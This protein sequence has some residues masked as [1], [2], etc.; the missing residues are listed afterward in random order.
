[1]W[2][3]QPPMGW[4]HMGMAHG[5]YPQMQ[6][7]QQQQ[8][9]APPAQ[10]P[11]DGVLRQRI[12]TVARFC[13]QNG[14]MFESST[15]SKEAHNPLF[16]FMFGGEGAEYFL[17]CRYCLSVGEQDPGACAERFL[18]PVGA[19]N[20]QQQQQQQ[21]VPPGFAPPPPPGMP[22]R[23]DGASLVPH[24]EGGQGSVGVQGGASSSFQGDPSSSSSSVPGAQSHFAQP[25]SSPEGGGEMD[26][27]IEYDL[28]A[29]LVSYQ[30][31]PVQEISPEVQKELS[32]VLD[33]LQP[34]MGGGGLS[35]ESVDKATMW[36]ECQQ[37]TV[38]EIALGIRKTLSSISD[39]RH[40]LNILAMVNGALRSS[41]SSAALRQSFRPFLLWILRSVYWKPEEDP[42]GGGSMMPPSDD[43]KQAV[44]QSLREWE[45]MGLI[46]S[47]ESAEMKFVVEQK[48]LPTIPHAPP[49]PS[50]SPDPPSA[51]SDGPAKAEG[52]GAETEAGPMEGVESH[53]A[54]PP[55]TMN[56]MQAP[57]NTFSSLSQP[58]APEA[59]I[60]QMQQQQQQQQQQQMTYGNAAM[61]PEMYHQHAAA[62]SQG[63]AWPGPMMMGG[64]PM[65]PHM[66][67][68][69]MGG[70]ALHHGGPPAPGMWG[71]DPMGGM[72]AGGG[73]GMNA[74]GFQEQ[75][76][77]KQTPESVPVGVMATM[78][79]EMSK[80]G[81]NL[82][83]AFVPYRPLDPLLTPQSSPPYEPPSELQ[84]ER[85]ADFFEDLRDLETRIEREEQRKRQREE[86]ERLREEE[87]ERREKEEERGGRRQ[88]TRDRDMERDE[89]PSRV[90]R[91]SRSR[92]L[93][94][95]REREKEERR[96]NRN[97]EMRMMSEDYERPTAWAQAE[98]GVAEDGTVLQKGMGERMGLGAMASRAD[99]DFE[100][101]R[102]ESS[103]KYQA[104]IQHSQLLANRGASGEQAFCRVCQ[105]HG[106]YAQD[107]KFVKDGRGESA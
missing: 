96:Y 3:Q 52:A 38:K 89:E 81:K 28:E 48:T 32:D 55:A 49:A 90:R 76:G 94:R 40:R 26:I 106:H 77:E 50:P 5:V 1:M 95:E 64:A 23:T 75:V 92:S 2:G 70:H 53:A 4:G 47:Y 78:L 13:Q 68:M 7:Q 85:L 36:L 82:Q 56:T 87:R 91:R 101:F 43:L 69:Q 11:S 107:C 12:E 20:A 61:H 27:Q 73:V 17:W 29:L 35:E 105:Q 60:A 93:S 54:S 22:P 62:M 65:P 19:Q 83:T 67:A 21:A 102:R 99:D 31:P 14:P 100:K 25:G 34:Q 42:G 44:T 58:L 45:R 51:F 98:A 33:S 63:G 80:R 84:L 57:S 41:G 18:G 74:G 16:Q 30:E 103:S 6:H 104:G 24:S 59:L 88:R 37:S 79:R 39:D 8:P 72:N 71:G 15:R 9:P 66:A 97:K 10:P 46:D 86:E